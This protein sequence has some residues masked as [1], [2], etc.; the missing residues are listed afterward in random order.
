M[1]VHPP[2]ATSIAAE[3]ACNDP[4]HSITRSD[5]AGWSTSSETVT[6]ATGALGRPLGVLEKVTSWTLEAQARRGAVLK[7]DFA[8]ESVSA[9]GDHG[10]SLR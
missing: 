7:G 9:N 6:E 8:L 10:G 4:T 3:S 1:S 2:R 5:I